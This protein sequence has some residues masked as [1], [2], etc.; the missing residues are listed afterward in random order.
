MLSQLTAIQTRE[1]LTDAKM[2]A[3]IGVARST[4]TDVRNGKLA[5]SERFQFLAVKAF[6]ELLGSLVTSVTVRHSEPAAS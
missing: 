2:A 3:R 1:G 4:W 5:M 6:P